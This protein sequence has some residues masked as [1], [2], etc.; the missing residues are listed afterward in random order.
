MMKGKGRRKRELL[1]RLAMA[2][3]WN[4]L[5]AKLGTVIDEADESA[6]WLEFS[7]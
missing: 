6:F 2:K 4:L 1:M 7:A 5:I 3:E